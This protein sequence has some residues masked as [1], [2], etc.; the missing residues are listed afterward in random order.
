MDQKIFSLGLS[1]PAVTLYL[2]LDALGAA[3]APVDLAAARPRWHASKDELQAALAELS[4][5][6]IASLHGEQARLTPP[7]SWQA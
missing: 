1:V 3:A 7:D 2:L 6:H 5:L 4:G